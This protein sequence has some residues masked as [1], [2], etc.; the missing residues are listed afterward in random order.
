MS[1]INVLVLSL[2]ESVSLPTTVGS[3]TGPTLRVAWVINGLITGTQALVH[4]HAHADMDNTRRIL[5][6]V[7]PHVHVCTPT[8][9]THAGCY[10]R[11]T[12]GVDLVP[13]IL[14]ACLSLLLQGELVG[15]AFNGPPIWFCF[16]NMCLSWYG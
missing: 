8:L 1:L 4:A 10:Q 3:P 2:T 13:L 5:A 15:Q 9:E 7:Q 16:L 12:W 14:R 11:T 6:D